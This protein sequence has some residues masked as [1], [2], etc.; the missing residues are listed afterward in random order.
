[1]KLDVKFIAIFLIIGLVQCERGKPVH[2]SIETTVSQLTGNCAYWNGRHVSLD[3]YAV[4]TG[5]FEDVITLWNSKNEA[6]S[7]NINP[8]IGI[9][10][11]SKA[12]DKRDWR[13]RYSGMVRISGTFECVSNDVVTPYRLKEVTVFKYL[14]P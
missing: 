12:F 8:N 13:K 11:L 10:T 1:M 9:M 7:K 3:C 14:D 4:I 5:K 6:T 2:T